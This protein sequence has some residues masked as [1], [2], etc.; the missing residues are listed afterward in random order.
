MRRLDVADGPQAGHRCRRALASLLCTTLFAL[1]A[2]SAT[3]GDRPNA[4]DDVAGIATVETGD[5]GWSH[6]GPD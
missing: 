4:S 1:S 3:D 6:A 2:C 5:D